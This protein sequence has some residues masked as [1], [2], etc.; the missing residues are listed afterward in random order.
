MNM[1]TR[2]LFPLV[3]TNCILE[4]T[5]FVYEIHDMFGQHML[6]TQEYSHHSIAQRVWVQKR[7]S[8]NIS[9]ITDTATCLAY[10]IRNDRLARTRCE[11]V[12]NT[13]P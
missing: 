11:V 12:A 7:A 6:P 8:D 2:V 9:A 3:C 4:I 1:Q 10:R 13:L 5:I